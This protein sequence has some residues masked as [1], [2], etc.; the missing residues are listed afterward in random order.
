MIV[1]LKGTPAPVS[2]PD[3]RRWYALTV[4][5]LAQF[6]VVLDVTIANVALPAIRSDLGF[7]A[8]GLQWVINAYTLAFGGLL[9][10]GGRAADLLG[11]RRVFF[12]GL[13]LFATA[14]LVA[15]LAGS[16]GMLIAAR[17]VQGV[18]GALLSPAA[19]AIVTV[20]FAAGRERNL[21]L[22]VWGALAG[23]GGTAGVVAGGL[24]VDQLGW[25]WIFFVNVPIAMVAAA[26]APFVVRESRDAGAPRSFDVAGALLATLGLVAIVLG[27]IRTDAAGWGSAQVIGLLALG[28]ALLAAFAAVEARVAA[29]L[30]PLSLLRARGLATS[31]LALAANGGAFLGMFFL[32][33]LFLQSVQGESALQAGVRFVPMGIGAILGAAAASQL[34][35]RIGTRAVF[36]VGAAVSVA[37]LYLLSRAGADAS[38]AT[39]L[40]PG[41]VIYGAAIPFI[42][43]PNQI[44]A[45]ASVPHALAGAASGA[46]TAAFQVGGALGLAVVTTLANARVTDALAA[47]ASQADALAAGFQRGLVVAAVLS[48]ANLVL[49]LVAAPRMLPDA[50]AVVAAEAA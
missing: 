4:V 10:L 39:D 44:S 45:V 19:L 31:G 35:T 8:D 23:L 21:A 5:A 12:A 48:A 9:L 36:L 38:Y 22:G 50:E 37:G 27:V 32:T 18:G 24:L 46:V 40:L 11:R 34:V 3:P 49:A 25:E 13:G 33:A 26:A 30:L 41:F 7:S 47:G 1:N 15:G 16:P 28:L 43:V 42:G 6:M 29:P 2:S 14:S 17:T 20:T